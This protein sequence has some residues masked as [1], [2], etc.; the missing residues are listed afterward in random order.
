MKTRQEKARIALESEGIMSV[1]Q[2]PSH[3]WKHNRDRDM[4]IVHAVIFA[5]RTLSSV[6]DQFGLSTEGV[7]TI[8]L[9]HTKRAIGR[10][11]S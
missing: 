10:Y 8:G 7:R 9:R 11:G 3:I 6:A 2:M 5:G 4:R 1:D